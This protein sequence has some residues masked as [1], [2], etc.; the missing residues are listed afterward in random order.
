MADSP[1]LCLHVGYGKTGSTFLQAWLAYQAKRLGAAGI[2]YPIPAEG[3]GDSGNGHL[4][5]EALAEPTALPPWLPAPASGNLLFSREHL[6]RE[7]AADGACE[8]LATWARRWQLGPVKV[9]L[10]VRD[11]QEHCYSLWAQKVKRAGE[12]RSL[13]RF[14]E[15]YDAITM[16]KRFVGAALMAGFEVQVLDYGRHRR[17]LVPRFYQWLGLEGSLEPLP[18]SEV[19]ANPTPQHGQLRLQRRLHPLWPGGRAPVPPAWMGRMLEAR[20]GL[21]A[22]APEQL[23]C[24]EEQAAEFNAFCAQSGITSEGLPCDKGVLR[25]SRGIQLT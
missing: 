19:S 6:A 15:S 12:R 18:A 16:V 8:R 14:A 24:W 10:L 13:E 2:H 7:L 22:L 25:N 23:Q 11:P 21:V 9:L 1:E 20:G 4:L 17:A 3:L 5:L